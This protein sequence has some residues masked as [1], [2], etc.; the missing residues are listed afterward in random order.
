MIPDGHSHA[1]Q[2]DRSVRDSK[3]PQ[4]NPEVDLLIEQNLNMKSQLLSGSTC[5]HD[6][7]EY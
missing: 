4:D 1:F 5:S 3:T 7:E 2:L 6:E